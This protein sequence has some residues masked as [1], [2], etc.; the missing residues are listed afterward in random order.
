MK[1]CLVYFIPKTGSPKSPITVQD[2]LYFTST[3]SPAIATMKSEET[4]SASEKCTK[5]R[6]IFHQIQVQLSRSTI[7]INSIKYETTAN[8]TFA[9]PLLDTL[10]TAGCSKMNAT[11]HSRRGRT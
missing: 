9:S 3:Y 10:K 6:Q 1:I 2:C 7:N 5:P 8:D 4:S 11:W